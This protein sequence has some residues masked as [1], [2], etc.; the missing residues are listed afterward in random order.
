MAETTFWV[1]FRAQVREAK[2]GYKEIQRQQKSLDDQRK[3]QLRFEQRAAR[4]QAASIRKI[5]REK[6]RATRREMLAERSKIRTS[7]GERRR[8]VQHQQQETRQWQQNVARDRTRIQRADREVRR[9]IFGRVA[10]GA[11][12]GAGFAGAGLIGMLIGG[13]LGGFRKYQE[14]AQAARGTVGLGIGRTTP[15]PG[16]IGEKKPGLVGEGSIGQKF[17]YNVAQTQALMAAAARATGVESTKTLMRGEA[18]GLPT[19]MMAGMMG[20]ITRGGTPFGGRGTWEE[21]GVVKERTQKGEGKEEFIKTL[22]KGFAAG[23]KLARMPE[24]YKGIQVLMEQQ[25][26]MTSGKVTTDAAANVLTLLGQTG[27]PGLRGARGAAVATKLQQGIMKPGGGPAGEA[28]VMQAFGYGK[29]GGTAGFYEAQKFMEQGFAGKGLEK[30]MRE[31]SR[32]G[33]STEERSLMMRAIFQTNLST[34]EDILKVFQDTSLSIEERMKKIRDIGVKDEGRAVDIEKDRVVALDRNTDVLQLNAKHFNKAVEVGATAAEG[35]RKIEELQREFFTFMMKQ[36]PNIV[37]GIE[38]LVDL[39]KRGK[40]A[41]LGTIESPRA[42][43]YF[44]KGKILKSQAEEAFSKGKGAEGMRLLEESTL[45]KQEASNYALE[46][47]KDVGRR[48]KVAKKR[49]REQQHGV[50]GSGAESSQFYSMIM[51]TIKGRVGDEEFNE[52]V[53]NQGFREYVGDYVKKI[54]GAPGM[55][56]IKGARGMKAAEKFFYKWVKK[57][58]DYWDWLEE[59]APVGMTGGARPSGGGAGLTAPAQS[60]TAAAPIGGAVAGGAQQVRVVFLGDHP[61]QI[62][63]EGATTAVANKRAR[64]DG[65]GHA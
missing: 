27:V 42:R 26:A 21:G 57:H 60:P 46:K 25:Q 28:L 5:S 4:Q 51:D 31:I 22:A 55:P 39:A 33:G 50:Y 18:Y 12:R 8:V 23:N 14:A 53:K 15:T 45:W 3:K 29:P 56:K 62:W 9:S 30:V 38:D 59:T 13:A 32:Q 34:N 35:I 6:E 49:T 61:G 16:R 19:D 11:T 10:S 24:Y 44:E 43:E 52:L 20:T 63:Q 40:E 48:D 41:V 2:K 64:A 47:S 54:H 58:P 1:K 36:I 37:K 65:S 7:E 17:G